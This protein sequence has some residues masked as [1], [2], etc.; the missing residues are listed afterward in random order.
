[1]EGSNMTTIYV[2]RWTR[3]A[4]VTLAGTLALGSASGCSRD[5]NKRKMKYLESGKK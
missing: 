3:M 5:P 1:M 2:S 4:A